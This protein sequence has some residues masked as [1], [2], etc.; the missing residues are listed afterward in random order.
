MGK[1]RAQELETDRPRYTV[2][3]PPLRKESKIPS[4]SKASL[5]IQPDLA[6]YGT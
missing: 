3:H 4:F 6:T 2:L 1:G 5:F